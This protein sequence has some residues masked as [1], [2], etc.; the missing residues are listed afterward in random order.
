MHELS[1]ATSLVEVAREE[2]ARRDARAVR[3]VYLKLGALSG[4]VREALEFAFDVATEGTVLEGA[5]LE[6]E[7][8]GARVFCPACEEEKELMRPAAAFRAACPTCGAP[9]P[10]IRGGDELELTALEID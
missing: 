1:I 4:V 6:I 2:A 8:V 3:A 10:E 7:E 9:A 5:A